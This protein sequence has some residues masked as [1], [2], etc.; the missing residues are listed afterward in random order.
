MIT[1]T[2]LADELKMDRRLILDWCRD[3][4]LIANQARKN[5]TKYTFSATEAAIAQLATLLISA[6]IHFSVALPA[7]RAMVYAGPK[8]TNGLYTWRAR[9]TSSI[10]LL[11]E[12]PSS[13][14][15]LTR[16][17]AIF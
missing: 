10:I 2:E 14:F 3:E 15:P 17:S 7:A 1:V 6:G 5:G 12:T 16:A 4:L 11:A 8:P 9:T 13:T